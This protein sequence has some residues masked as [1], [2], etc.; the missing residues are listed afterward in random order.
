MRVLLLTG[1]G[2]VGKT[3]TAAATAVLAAARGPEDARGEHRLRALPRRRARGGPRAGAGRGRHR[4]LRDA[5][6]RPARRPS[7]PGARCRATCSTP[8]PGPAWTR[9]RPRS[10][11]CCPARRRSWR[12][13]RCASTS[14]PGCS[15][16]SSWTAPPPRRR[17]GCS[18]CPQVLG[19]Y[20]DR[21]FPRQRRI[22]RA[23]R[24][25]LGRTGAALPSRRRVRDRRAAARRPRRGAR[26]AHRPGGRLGAPG[27]H[28]GAGRR[29]RGAPDAD[30]ASRSTATGWTR[31]W[32]TGCSRP[33]SGE[34]AVAGRLGRRPGRSSWRWCEEQFAPLPVH[35]RRLRRGRAGGPGGAAAPS[36][37][38]STATPTPWPL[39]EPDEL[40]RVER[41]GEGFVLSVALP[42]AERGQHRPRP[43]RRR[44]R[45]S[46]SGGTAGCWACPR[47]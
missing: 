38:T 37:R 1:K 4:P 42:L 6:R 46:P 7:G 34:D 24:P 12:C 10:S 18:R 35:R 25:A 29:R 19:W 16:S 13:W 28:P 11:P 8:S 41:D 39:P 23:L 15:T 27:A 40:V 43:Q 17:C 30:L 44:A 3:T 47:R 22:A 36:P 9:S 20:M 26:A 21:V 32:R 33:P 5:G 31:S 45:R 14:P 2:G